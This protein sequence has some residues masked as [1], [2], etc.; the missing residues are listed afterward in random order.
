M[1]IELLRDYRGIKIDDELWLKGVYEVEDDLGAYLIGKGYAQATIA[2]L[3]DV[4]EK[5]APDAIAIHNEAVED[6]GLPSHVKVQPMPATGS[7]VDDSGAKKDYIDY[8]RDVL[9]DMTE[10]RGIEVEGTGQAGYVTKQNLL[11]ALEDED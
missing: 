8:S 9:L 5:A 3:P 7:E 6:L 1:R 4:S 2:P 11:D 10:K